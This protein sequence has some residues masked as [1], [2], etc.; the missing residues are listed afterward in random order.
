MGIDDTKKAMDDI[1]VIKES[2]ALA[3][4]VRSGMFSFFFILWGAIYLIGFSGSQFLTNV[5]SGKLWLILSIVGIIS[6]FVGA[7]F[8][9]SKSVGKTGIR[10][11]LF[12]IMLIIYVCMWIFAMGGLDYRLLSFF[13]ITTA[14]FGYVVMGLWFDMRIVFSALVVTGLAVISFLFIPSLSALIMGILGGGTMIFSGIYLARLGKA[15][16]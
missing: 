2:I 8:L 3:K 7:F 10:I 13:L 1:K 11:M 15:E 12:W 4:G 6:N 16:A 9:G 14:M 5:L